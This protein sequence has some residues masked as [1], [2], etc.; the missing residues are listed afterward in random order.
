MQVTPPKSPAFIETNDQGRKNE[1]SVFRE[2]KKILQGMAYTAGC[3]F[4]C[5]MEREGLH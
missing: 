3:F 5:D 1:V 4:R 2:D